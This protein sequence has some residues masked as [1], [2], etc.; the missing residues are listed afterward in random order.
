MAPK[1]SNVSKLLFKKFRSNLVV[2][3][4]SPVAPAGLAVAVPAKGLALGAAAAPNA[5]APNPVAPTAGFGAPN[6]ALCL[7]IREQW[8]LRRFLP[9][10]SQ[11]SFARTLCHQIFKSFDQ[12]QLNLREELGRTLF[13]ANCFIFSSPLLVTEDNCNSKYFKF[14]KLFQY[15]S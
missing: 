7:S 6:M 2:N 13:Q 3:C 8:F 14:C 15:Y 10:F 11:R 4:H 5:D 12:F 1:I 9:D